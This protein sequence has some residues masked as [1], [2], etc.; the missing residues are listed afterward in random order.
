DLTPD[1]GANVVFTLDL[2]NAAGFSTATNVQVTDNLPAGYTFVSAAGDGSY[3]SGTGVWDVAS[4]A[5]G[6]TASIDITATVLGSGSYQND[7]EVTAADQSDTDDTYGNGSGEDFATVTPVPNPRIDLS[8]SKVVD[9][10]SPDVGNN[11]EFTITVDNAAG[12]TDATGVAVTDILPA[13]YSY[14]SDDSGGSYNSG[15]GV[16]TIGGLSAG[17][18]AAL[19][20]TATVLGSGSYTN[21]AE[22]TAA[23][24]TDVDST[25]GDSGGDDYDTESVSPGS[26]IDLSLTKVVDNATPDVGSNV[27]FTITVDNAAG[28]S[29]ATGVAVTDILPAGYSYVSDD[30]GGSYNSGTGV[31]T[32]GGLAAGANAVLKITATVL[33]SGS[34]SNVAEVTAAVETDVDSTP[35]DSGGDDYDTA[36]TTPNPRI[37]LSLTKVVD[38][39]TPDVGSNVEFTITVNNAAG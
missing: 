18:N 4:V 24:E 31:W 16:W 13:G 12:F 6:A 25:P 17:A 19:K 20:I 35:G 5:A 21:A 9:N 37:D 33:G 39:G 15:T 28:F 14:V 30:S 1:V 27:E 10:G 2:T 7:A 32:I 36:G 29:D 8:L 34:Y 23:G 3:S 22:V 11:V 38:N 26:A